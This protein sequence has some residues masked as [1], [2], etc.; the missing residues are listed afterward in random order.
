MLGFANTITRDSSGTAAREFDVLTGDVCEDVGKTR[1]ISSGPGKARD[2]SA[3]DRIADREHDNRNPGSCLL[4]GLNGRRP[5]GEDDI[6]VHL[7]Q[8]RSQGRK[9]LV[10]TLCPA[11]LDRDVL[12]L[13]KPAFAQPGDRVPGR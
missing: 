9:A 12:A 7:H 6:H 10:L 13:H 8:F 11:V 1:D 4:G 2:E 3:R 5:A